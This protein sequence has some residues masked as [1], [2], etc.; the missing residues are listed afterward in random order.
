MYEWI[1]TANLESY[2]VTFDEDLKDY[3]LTL[4]GT[5]FAAN[6]SNTEVL[7]DNMK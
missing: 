1:D 5:G 3:I 7:I 6:T 2:S 4:T